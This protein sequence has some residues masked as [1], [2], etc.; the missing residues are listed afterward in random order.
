MNVLLLA[1]LLVL[2]GINQS[3]VA[4]QSPPPLYGA[5]HEMVLS[6]IIEDSMPVIFMNLTNTP[7]HLTDNITEEKHT[8]AKRAVLSFEYDKRDG[9]DYRERFSTVESAAWIIQTGVAAVTI[10]LREL[11]NRRNTTDFTPTFD[12]IIAIDDRVFT[13]QYSQ[14]FTPTED[15]ARTCGESSRMQSAPRRSLSCT[16]LIR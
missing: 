7:I 2:S 16:D 8:I 14:V 5:I 6:P 11:D 12:S 15:T 10:V 4:M 13:P 3:V 1:S 9:F